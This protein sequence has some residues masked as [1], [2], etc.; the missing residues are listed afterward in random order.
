M[1]TQWG[2]G[3]CVAPGV[4]TSPRA[5]PEP[6]AGKYR[7]GVGVSVMG[8]P[9]PQ[10]G[11][12]THC[13]H[14]SGVPKIPIVKAG[15][16]VGTQ[17]SPPHRGGSGRGVTQECR[18]ESVSVG[19]E[20]GVGSAD[21]QT[22]VGPIA[23]TQ[24]SRPV[25][26]HNGQ[27]WQRARNWAMNIYSGRRANTAPGQFNCGMGIARFNPVFLF[28]PPSFFFFASSLAQFCFLGR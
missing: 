11:A 26:L 1:G 24:P 17:Q 21:G 16:T 3:G 8:V 28:L 19:Q 18:T 10:Q 27:Q 4:P 15:S 25:P 5:P 22:D 7:Q 6:T 23:T 13:G 2:W 12:Q 9:M 14:A 20:D